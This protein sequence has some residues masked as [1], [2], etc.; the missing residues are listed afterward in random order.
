M[1]KKNNKKNKVNEQK[2]HIK[3]IEHIIERCDKD[4]S[5]I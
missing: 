1:N 2:I 4:V 5:V 3:D